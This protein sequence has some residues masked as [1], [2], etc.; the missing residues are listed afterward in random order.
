MRNA[1]VA[2]YSWRLRECQLAADAASEEA[3]DA[4]R[5][6]DAEKAAADAARADLAKAAEQARRRLN[7]Y[8]AVHNIND[9]TNHSNDT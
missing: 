1:Q 7:A 8:G 3:A 5:R 4:V 2:E 6:A 9:I